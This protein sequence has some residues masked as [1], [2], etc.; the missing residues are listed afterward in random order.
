MIARSPRSAAVSAY[1]KSRSG[2]RCAETTRVS[3]GISRAASV[4]A[5][6]D[7]SEKPVVVVDLLLN[8]EEMGDAPLRSIRMRSDRFD[9][10]QLVPP[11]DTPMD[12]LRVLMKELLAI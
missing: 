12:A 5:V 4:A 7:L 6:R 9:P 2:V 1:S 11:M 10:S 8:W 3:Q